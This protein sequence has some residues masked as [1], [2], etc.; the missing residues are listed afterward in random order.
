MEW[1]DLEDSQE[2][3]M[4]KQGHEPWDGF[5]PLIMPKC[6]LD[7]QRDVPLTKLHFQVMN[8][9]ISDASVHASMS[10]TLEAVWISV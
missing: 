2:T 3:K 5:F 6:V 1:I 8:S 7:V 9:N 10:K 4:L